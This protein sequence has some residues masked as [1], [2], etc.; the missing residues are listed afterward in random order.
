MLPAIQRTRAA[1]RP[2]VFRAVVLA[3]VGTGL[4][5]PFPAFADSGDAP[6]AAVKAAPEEKP[7]DGGVVD[8]KPA[9]EDDSRKKGAEGGDA[10]PPGVYARVNGRDVT[11]REYAEYLLASLGKSHLGRYID[12]ILIETEARRQG[13]TVAPE[14][15]EK[16]VE[17]R[18]QRTVQG[19]YRGNREAF[20]EAL[21]RR[22]STLQ[23][24]KQRDRQEIYYDRLLEGLILK[25]R[26]IDDA[27]LRAEF[28]R[29]HGPGGVQCELRHVLVSTRR[30]IG[31]QGE[32]LAARTAAEARER[33]NKIQQEL[34]GGAD[35]AQLVA[36]YSD[37]PFTRQNDGRVPVYR[38]GLF[39]A[40][41]DAAVARLK[42]DSPLSGPVRSKQGIHLIQLVDRRTT[43][44]E[45]V[46]ADIEKLVRSRPPT[47]RERQG[48]LQKL[49][50][51]ATV[52]R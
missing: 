37:D 33:A 50:A 47:S 45:D 20:L 44:L 3:V 12:R 16:L 26:T 34:L 35:F 48:A 46:R 7:A 31:P 29:V 1:A 42:Q 11:E 51:A 41:F 39:G 9:G 27:S 18:L 10:L 22:H 19:I 49:R 8:E 52:A 15:I 36:R 5:G 30:R 32:R 28:E 23:E 6:K 43:K 4:A 25:S 13:V 21:T 38:K 2:L 24:R 40:E 14:E 17:E